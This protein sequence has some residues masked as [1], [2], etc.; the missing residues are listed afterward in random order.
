MYKKN[1]NLKYQIA[2]A[3][4]NYVM[5]LLAEKWIIKG[6]NSFDQ[7]KELPRVRKVDGTINGSRIRINVA[8]RGRE[9]FDDLFLSEDIN[10]IE[11]SEWFGVTEKND[12]YIKCYLD[13]TDLSNFKDKPLYKVLIAYLDKIRGYRFEPDSNLKDSYRIEGNVIYV[14]RKCYTKKDEEGNPDFQ[15]NVVISK[16]LNKVFPGFIEIYEFWGSNL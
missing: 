14:P 2:K 9:D 1:N 4:K 12:I 6:Y 7:Y 13:T 5:R 16:E 10:N 15:V 11:N 3:R 8:N